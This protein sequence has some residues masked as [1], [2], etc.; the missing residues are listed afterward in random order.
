MPALLLIR[1]GEV[2]DQFLLPEGGLGIGRASVNQIRLKS[3]SVSERHAR[4]F[5][6]DSCS[7]IKD[8]NS[9][10]GT[11][12]NDKFIRRCELRDN[13]TILIGSYKLR[14]RRGDNIEPNVET[15]ASTETAE[16]EP[17]PPSD[18]KQEYPQSDTQPARRPMDG[19]RDRPARL[20]V[21][22]GI[23]KGQRLPLQADKLVL[24][25]QNRRNLIIE[26]SEQGYVASLAPTASEVRFNGSPMRGA[27]IL[28]HDDELKVEDVTLR[29]EDVESVASA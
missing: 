8:L 2:I 14:F 20:L 26:A 5:T 28:C 13:D 25:K 17:P 21:L 19:R 29:F 18:T 15:T 11:F 10:L 6:S 9:A 1:K 22:D 12:V 16:S 24:G 23:N 27:V 4:I 3:P 7:I